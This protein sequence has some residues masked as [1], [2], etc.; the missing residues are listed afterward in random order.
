VRLWRLFQ[1]GMAPGHLPEAGG[2]LD[3]GAWLL[4]A[5]SIMTAAERELEKGN[6]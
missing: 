4:E 6:G 3:Q 5:F 2:T 1:G